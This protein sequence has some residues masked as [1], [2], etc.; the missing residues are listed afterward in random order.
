MLRYKLL[1]LQYLRPFLCCAGNMEQIQESCA[2]DPDVLPNHIEMPKG[3]D[4][5]LT[6]AP[7]ALYVKELRPVSRG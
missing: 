1:G 6:I 7:E 2:M 5:W 3:N 4:A